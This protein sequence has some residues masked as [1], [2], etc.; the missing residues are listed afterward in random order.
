MGNKERINL[1]MK[2]TMANRN[3]I[4][5]IVRQEWFLAL[6][7]NLFFL[8]FALIFRTPY[9]ETNDDTGMA[10]LAS[11]AYG[12]ESEFLVFINIIYGYFLKFFY[13]I[14]PNFNW[15]SF[16]ELTI[17]FFSITIVGYIILKKQSEKL[18]CIV[19]VFVLAI[20]YNEFY[21]ILQFTR[22]S[23]LSC[24]AG[25]LLF[26]YALEE[27]QKKISYIIGGIFVILGFLMR[28]ASFKAVTLF[29]A[30]MGVYSII[31]TGTVA[32]LL[33][34]KIKPFMKYVI[35]FG[36]LFFIIGCMFCIDYFAYYSNDEWREYKEY[37]KLRA[38]LTDYGWPDYDSNQDAFQ[39]MGISENDY[40]LFKSA[41]MSDSKVLTTE[42]IEEIISLKEPREFDLQS[43][44]YNMIEYLYQYNYLLIIIGLSLSSLLLNKNVFCKIMP[45]GIGIVFFGV[46]CYYDYLERVVPRVLFPT[47]FVAIVCQLYCYEKQSQIKRFISTRQAIASIILICC[48]TSG[49]YRISHKNALNN[50][51]DASLLYQLLEDKE[52]VY[53]A[54]IQVQGKNYRFFDAFKTFEKDFYSNQINF[55]GWLSRTPTLNGVIEKLGISDVK[56]ALIE[57]GNVFFYTEVYADVMKN[58]IEEHTEYKD[59]SYSIYNDGGIC[60]IIKYVENRRDEDIKNIV[61]EMVFYDSV[62]E[63]QLFDGYYDINMRIKQE[64]A[65]KISEDSEKYIRV[66]DRDTNAELLYRVYQDRIEDE[67]GGYNAFHAVVPRSDVEKWSEKNLRFDMIVK[68]GSSFICYQGN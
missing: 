37:T 49:N 29:A 4:K 45:L 6:C 50:R 57:K 8:V 16:F 2:K 9:N 30:V 66:V 21:L 32:N 13:Y 41:N 33:K 26:F 19:Y 15:Y 11:G 61:P 28:F 47:V 43:C 34:R 24:I 59:I 64:E 20:F 25:Y 68:D 63:S 58:Y 14:I 56:K 10:A 62:E 18:G 52:K 54:D 31:K 51:M 38:E 7:I 39:K 48:I 23:M 35:S 1:V 42:K 5:R 3:D 60:K 22:V 46:L 55:G 65:Q 44:I 53:V 27:N 17:A 36:V 12:G 67:Q 40:V